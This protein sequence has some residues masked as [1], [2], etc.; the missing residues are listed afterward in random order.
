MT[1]VLVIEIKVESTMIRVAIIVHRL[2]IS[3]RH[4]IPRSP[5]SFF[6]LL[7]IVVVLVSYRLAKVDLQ[8][9]DLRII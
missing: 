1:F 3:A 9:I 7:E 4:V 2:V 6:H 8:A 5:G